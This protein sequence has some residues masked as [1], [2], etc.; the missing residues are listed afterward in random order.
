MPNIR[1]LFAPTITVTSI[2]AAILILYVFVIQKP[3]N[4]KDWEVGFQTQSEI[5]TANNIVEVNNIRNWQYD[6]NG[7]NT[8]Q[9]YINE[10]YDMDKIE[11]VWFLVEPFSGFEG[12]AHTYFVFDFNDGKTIAVSVEA[13]REKG[14]DFS[15][16]LGLFNKFELMHVWGT[17]RDLT[18]SRIFVE[19]SKI[20]MYLLKMPKS[21]SR[22]LFA[23]MVKETHNT[24]LNP[25]FYNTLTDNCTNVLAQ[26]ANQIKPG[27]IPLHF[28]WILPGYSD[29]LL[30]DLGFI[31]RSKAFDELRKSSEISERVKSGKTFE[32]VKDELGGY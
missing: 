11:S 9:E 12:I 27:V 20:Y 14:E 17:E 7:K 26:A 15:A 31:S 1:N 25:R 22:N 6:E 13:R 24:N 5:F 4:N 21:W 32:E 30:Y 28:S 3:S 8:K 16:L 29:Q 10:T 2:A 19:N 23:Q 18:G